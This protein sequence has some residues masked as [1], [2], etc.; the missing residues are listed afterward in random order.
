MITFI[1]AQKPRIMSTSTRASLERAGVTLLRTASTTR[2]S[3]RK[4]TADALTDAAAVRRRMSRRSRGRG[5]FP[6]SRSNALP[7]AG[8][9]CQPDCEPRPRT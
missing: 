1:T 5:A 6:A 7:R 9:P 2:N 3:Q 8:W 4:M